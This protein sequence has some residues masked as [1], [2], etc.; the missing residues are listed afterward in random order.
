MSQVTVAA[1]SPRAA[2]RALKQPIY[3]CMEAP[4]LG[5]PVNLLTWFQTPIGGA[6]N[7]TAAAKTVADTNL[8]QAGQLGVPQ[9]FDLYGFNFTYKH[10]DGYYN[11]AAA[12]P[13]A[14][15]AADL[16]EVYEASVFKFFFG[17]QRPWLTVP[18]SRVPHGT[19]FLTGPQDIQAADNNVMSISN[20]ESAK[21]QYYKFLANDS[22]IAI[23]SAENFSARIEWPLAAFGLT[24]DGTQS[25]MFVYLVG[26]L[27]TAL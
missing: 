3:D 16:L 26:V 22:Q 4:G 9:E 11:A 23:H 25:R 27:Y 10:D 5:A 1:P 6:L 15:L 24:A 21:E 2:L 17:Q 19:F 12:D 8:T 14:N 7:V 13:I 20:G 18:L